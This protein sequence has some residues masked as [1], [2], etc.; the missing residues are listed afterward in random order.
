MGNCKT[1]TSFKC[2]NVEFLL[3]FY[4]FL[5][6]FLALALSKDLA[7]LCPIGVKVFTVYILNNAKF[8]FFWLFYRN[9]SDVNIW[10]RKISFPLILKLLS[11]LSQI[12]LLNY[13]DN[14][15]NL[16]QF[17]SIILWKISSFLLFPALILWLPFFLFHLIFNFKNLRNLKVVK[18]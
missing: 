15:L 16:R 7:Q 10:K 17:Q 18:S 12:I 1:S 9:L 4:C 6:F 8:R 2:L 5:K 3:L 14:V 11:S 13:L